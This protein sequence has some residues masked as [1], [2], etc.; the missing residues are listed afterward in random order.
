MWDSK[1]SEKSDPDLKQIIPDS[2]HRVP[3]IFSPVLGPYP[4][5][6]TCQSVS[7]LRDLLNVSNLLR[8]LPQRIPMTKVCV[9]F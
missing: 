1:P 5:V 2:Q 9:C 4:V 8:R 3:T 6:I 7:H